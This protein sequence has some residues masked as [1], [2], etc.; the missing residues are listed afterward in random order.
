MSFQLTR[1]RRLSLFAHTRL[2]SIALV[3]IQRIQYVGE[4]E[5]GFDEFVCISRILGQHLKSGWP[6]LY[7]IVLVVIAVKC[8]YYDYDD[9]GFWVHL[10]S[11][12]DL[13][14]NQMNQGRIGYLIEAKLSELGRLSRERVGA[15]RYVGAILEQA[16][17]AQ[18]YIARYAEFLRA[19]VNQYGWDG[20][21]ALSYRS[22]QEIPLINAPWYLI[23][24]LHDQ[25][26]WEL[27]RDTA[28][29]MSQYYRGVVNEQEL[30]ARRGYQPG[31]WDTLISQLQL[32]DEPPRRVERA[33]P[34]LPKLVFDPDFGEIVLAFDREWVRQG[35]YRR[36]GQPVGNSRLP[37]NSADDFSGSITIQIRSQTGVW[38]TTEIPGWNPST[39]R[40]ALFSLNKG[41]INQLDGLSPGSYF[42]LAPG[43]VTV[44]EYLI[45]IDLGWVFS[46]VFGQYT[47]WQ[48]RL[49][50]IEQL[51]FL[52]YDPPDDIGSK[53]FLSWDIC[54]RRQ[55]LDGASDFSDVFTGSLPR[56]RVN[57]GQL[58]RDNRAA[59]F[60][61]NEAGT[62]RE[63]VGFT[64]DDVLLNIPVE[65]PSKGQIWVEPIARMRQS[66][67]RGVLD[68]LSYVLLPECS[69]KWPVELLAEDERA[70]ARL[71]G[72]PRV[73]LELD[74]CE[75]L[76]DDARQWQIPAEK[77][78]V[79]GRL[80][81]SNISVRVAKRLFRAT[82]H[83]EDQENE[84]L[85][86]AEELQGDGEL[87]ATGI[88]GKQGRLYLRTPDE[89]NQGLGDIGR[90]NIRG[91]IV[92]SPAVIRDAIMALEIPC[93]LFA[94]KA[95]GLPV[96]TKTRFIDPGLIKEVL[97]SGDAIRAWAGILDK[98]LFD[99]LTMASSV[100]RGQATSVDWGLTEVLPGSLKGWA[101]DLLL[102]GAVFD[103][104]DLGNRPENL[105][106]E[107]EDSPLGST[108]KWYIDAKRT[109]EGQENNRSAE[110]II[111]S[112]SRLSQLSVQRWQDK[113]KKVFDSLNNELKL[114]P[115]I[116]EWAKSVKGPHLVIYPDP[117]SEKPGGTDLTN[118]W[119]A[120]RHG[121][122]NAYNLASRLL[123]EQVGSP[124]SDLAWLV[125]ALVLFNN[126]RK[127]RIPNPPNQRHLRLEPHL[128]RLW[129]RVGHQVKLPPIT[130]AVQL[131][132]LPL[133]QGDERWFEDSN[134]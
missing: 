76:D 130:G 97:L 14:N 101:R 107:V 52:G 12:L 121:Y 2:L 71:K 39:S 66:A 65:P 77:N 67:G 26:G 22:Y 75:A 80:S 111:N 32:R 29:A 59:L 132:Y 53:S 64:E 51:E 84:L 49:A 31:F 6:P 125:L 3:E 112:F 7:P 131:K 95:G 87:V 24:F 114:T 11:R 96:H 5:L 124:V 91:E 18:R 79:E 21:R 98:A 70:K 89:T 55:P 46:E 35:A 85:I 50:R 115:W 16:G 17:V 93:G 4:I 62:R 1:I 116:R 127:K 19:G 10:F 28:H 119:R 41:Y 104:L 9:D 36:N 34:P 113:I 15:F 90:F 83:S 92:F 102:C 110:D 82:L 109:I 44:P 117:I 133:N 105:F 78:V 58:F 103:G 33:E 60:I 69:V 120:Y 134:E 38:L 122:P 128:M 129:R 108:L 94:V 72:D 56:L 42:F 86:S 30:R 20:L 88:P 8:A 25:A 45:E 37:L 63:R 27:T 43:D 106:D 118:A 61:E 74:G 100:I 54:E 23:S 40:F 47:A 123:S 126:D 73:T 48:I 13:P 81:I 99:A 57:Q 68:K